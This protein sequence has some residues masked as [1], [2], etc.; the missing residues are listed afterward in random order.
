MADTA[1]EEGVLLPM[2]KRIRGKWSVYGRPV[3]VTIVITSRRRWVK[4]QESREPLWHS[5]LLG[6]AV[7]AMGI[8]VGEV[9]DLA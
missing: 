2:N 5:F 7:L 4:M 9:R 6:P 8:T 3:E 1:V